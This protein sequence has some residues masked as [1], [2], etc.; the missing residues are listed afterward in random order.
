MKLAPALL[1]RKIITLGLNLNERQER[2]NQF[3]SEQPA[4]LL[5][6]RMLDEG[7]D[8]PDIDAAILV[9]STKSKRQRIQRFGRVLRKGE[10]KPLIITLIVPETNEGRI[11]QDDEETFQGAADLHNANYN[12]AKEVVHKLL[13]EPG[14][15]PEK[16]EL[17]P[18]LPEEHW[19]RLV[20]FSNDAII[21]QRT[22]IKNRSDITLLLTHP[23]SGRDF[24]HL[25][26]PITNPEIS[27]KTI[28]SLLRRLDKFNPSSGKA[29][30]P[31]DVIVD[32]IFFSIEG[33]VS[34]CSLPETIKYYY[35]NNAAGKYFFFRNILNSGH[36][37]DIYL[38]S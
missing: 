35:K 24:E 33:E 30:L 37:W 11:I 36:E 2:L 27:K 15:I 20:S 32:A 3:K 29:F 21:T 31:N 19:S 23:N 26:K 9:A 4:I 1:Q 34:Q 7:I 17:K 16:E 25:P 22:E 8:V 18:I 12:T 6:C 28:N 14:E 10:K 13:N 5:T 38:L